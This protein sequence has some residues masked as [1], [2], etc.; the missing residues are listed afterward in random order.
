MSV[1]T[2]PELFFTFLPDLLYIYYAL[3]AHGRRPE[4]EERGDCLVAAAGPQV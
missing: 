2:Y 3:L 1:Y 4:E